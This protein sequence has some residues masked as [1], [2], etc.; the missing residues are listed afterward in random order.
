[1]CFL[2]DL[3][4]AARFLLEQPRN[5]LLKPLVG[6]SCTVTMLPQ[7]M[8]R[9]NM[10]PHGVRTQ[11]DMYTFCRMMFGEHADLQDY[12]NRLP[13][14]RPHCFLFVSRGGCAPG[15]SLG[16][17]ADC[18]PDMMEE[19]TRNAS[20]EWRYMRYVNSRAG[21][22]T[23][24]AW[25]DSWF[26]SAQ[27]SRSPCTCTFTFGGEGTSRLRRLINP[28]CQQW[29]AGRHFESVFLETIQQNSNQ[30]GAGDNRYLC[31]TFHAM[32][33]RYRH[34]ANH[35]IGWHS[36]VMTFSWDPITTLN[37]GATGV[38]L[39]RPKCRGATVEKVLVILPGDAYIRGG[40]FQQHFEFSR[41]PI[42]EW[43]GL[44]QQHRSELLALEIHAMQAAI[45]HYEQRSVGVGYDICVRWHTRHGWECELRDTTEV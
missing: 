22:A 37:W 12:S 36:E 30:A 43:A 21:Y 29:A 10:W 34:L 5:Q 40:D 28:S 23:G 35:R 26:E 2:C 17:L 13:Q 24:A 38:L 25:T 9:Q 19:L 11:Q 8:T 6:D 7:P 4:N 45:H 42:N 3:Q 39:M 1:M 33:N 18:V 20:T 44:L 16:R 27:L 15:S 41:P 31:K 14:T 32:L